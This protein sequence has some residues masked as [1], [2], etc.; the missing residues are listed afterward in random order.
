VHELLAASN[1]VPYGNGLAVSAL[2][3]I[4]AGVVIA[5]ITA[6]AGY[7]IARNRKLYGKVDQQG[8][9]LGV[10][11]RA[12]VTPAPTDIE[13]NPKPGLV[14]VVMGKDGKSGL[15]KEVQDHSAWMTEVKPILE[16]VKP[17]LEQIKN[18][19]HRVAENLG[20]KTGS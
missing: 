10:I 16:E 12:L 13:P 1:Q 19:Q 5:A 7:I 6:V 15:Y 9:D 14:E 20:P 8:A 18:E 3:E 17:M 4:I 2:G 11:R